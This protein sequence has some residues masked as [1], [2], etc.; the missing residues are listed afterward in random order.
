LLLYL[1]TDLEDTRWLSYIWE[2]FARI[3]QAAFPIRI[4]PSHACPETGERLF[5]TRELSPGVCIPNRS[6]RPPGEEVLWLSHQLFI[7]ANTWV[8]DEPFACP[9]DLFWNA[10]VFLSRLEEYLSDQKGKKSN[11]Y[12]GNHPR[13]DKATF[14]IPVVNHLFNAL[15]AMIQKHFPGLSFGAGEK[16]VIEFSH[17]VDYLQKT[18]QLRVKQTALNGLNA[19]KAIAHPLEFSRLTK[20]T[21]RFLFSNPSYWCFDYWEELEKRYNQ[22]SVFYVYVQTGRKDWKSWLI[23]PSY[24]LTA[25]QRLPRRLKSLI[26][27]GF[28]VGLHGS[29]HSATDENKLVQEKDLL[30]KSIGGGVTKIRQHWLRYE[31]SI[32]PRLHNK[33][34]HFDS[35]LGWNDRLGFRSGC[36]SRHRPYDHANQQ[37]FAHFITPQVIMDANI[38]DYGAGQIASLQRQALQLI[39]DLQDYKNA[40]ISINWHQRVKNEDYAWHELYEKIIASYSTGG[41]RS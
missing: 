27:A 17:D 25:D 19:L 15:E 5:Y 12:S 33:Y 6:G 1:A 23:D 36:G 3:N 35:S 13:K 34:F 30:E 10:F 7:L 4:L 38:F 24:N 32:T 41:P 14:G 22:H 26:R 39:T 29:W 20:K 8:A 40:Y 21:L 28:E 9:Y 2:E 16:P 18:F 37:P 11:S 31:E